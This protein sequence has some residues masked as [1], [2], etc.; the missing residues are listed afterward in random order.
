MRGLFGVSYYGPLTLEGLSAP[1]FV[2]TLTTLATG[3][4]CRI[5]TVDH[6]RRLMQK[7]KVRGSASLF[8]RGSA[9]AIP[10]GMRGSLVR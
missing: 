10:E 8:I 2:N 1:V 6:H 5:I 3:Q 4:V 9:T 7:A